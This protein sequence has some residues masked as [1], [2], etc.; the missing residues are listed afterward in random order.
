MELL[1]IIILILLNGIFSMSEVALISA[2]KSSIT[3]SAKKGS[4]SA[5]NVL[6]LTKEPNRFLSTIQIGITLIG[7]LTGLYSGDSIATKFSGILEEWG[8]KASAAQPIAQTSIIVLVT[9]FTLI[10]GELVPKRLGMGAPENIAKAVSGPMIILSWVGRPFVWILD[11]S[12]NAIVSILNIG[13][14]AEAKVTEDEIK[15]MIAEGT[16]DGEVQEVEQDIVERVFSLGDRKIESIM[17]SRAEMIWID[18][19]MTN[20]EINNTVQE[21]LFEVYPVG[22]GSLDKIIGVVYL[23]DLFG[24]LDKSDFNLEKYIRPAQY[25][26]EYT[27]VY[28]VMEQMKA[29]QVVYGLI[30]DEFGVCQGIVTYKDILE[31]LV[32]T[33][34][35]DEGEPEIIEREAGGWLV[36]GQCSFYDFLA[37]FDMEEYAADN[38]Y[39]TLGG[40]V[41]ELLEHIPKTGESVVWDKFRLEVVDMD[42]VRID[43]ILV[44]RIEEKDKDK[45]DRY[46]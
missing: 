33:L 41:L 28:K 6:N 10:L 12:T 24:K 18:K 19:D 11:K 31:G 26:H 36:D 1:I 44:T 29:Q 30:C 22:D 20:E 37:H 27:D 8:I 4:R 34:D 2:R 23:K 42:G 7:I 16:E 5:K 43:K 17:T 35:N 45:D 15:S 25:F 9:Y 38:D 21:N 39:N 13:K 40:L 3:A 14:N 32:G 46:E